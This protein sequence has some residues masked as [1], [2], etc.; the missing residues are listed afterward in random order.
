M[1]ATWAAP[2]CAVAVVGVGAHAWAQSTDKEA[3]RPVAEAAANP[4]EDFIR[5]CAVCHGT[6]GRGNGP[7][8]PAMKT[9]PADLTKIATRNKGEFPSAKVADVIRNGG[10][11]LGHGSTAMPAWGLDFSEKHNPTVARGRIAGLVRYIE[12]LQEK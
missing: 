6:D 8:A 10:G 2:A 11:V 9:A 3:T 1:I 5:H 12:S 7:L 4:E